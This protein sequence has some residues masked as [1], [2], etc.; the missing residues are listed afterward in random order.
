[1]EQGQHNFLCQNPQQKSTFK[2]N[3]EVQDYK[4]SIAILKRTIKALQA[5]SQDDTIDDI[6]QVADDASTES[7]STMS[8]C[9][10]K[11]K[12]NNKVPKCDNKPV[13]ST[14]APS[15]PYY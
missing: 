5:K 3:K 9:A 7:E 4:H 12:L 15:S 8:Q 2:G 13:V 11:S 6:N 14:C 10:L 1:M